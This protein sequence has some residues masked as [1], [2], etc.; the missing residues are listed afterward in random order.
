MTM[1]AMWKWSAEE[2]AEHVR[3]GTASATEV[4][5]AHLD[6]LDDVNPGINAVTFDVRESALAAAAELDATFAASG[7]VGPLHGV[8]ITIKENHDVEGQPS[9][10]G[11]VAWE[12]RIAPADAPM[13]TNLRQAGAVIVGRTNAPELSYRWHTDNPLRGETKNPWSRNRTP[14]GSSGGAAASLAA[15]IGTIAHGN[16]LGGSIRQPANCCGLVGI[17]PTLGRI[18]AFNPSNEAPLTIGLQL[19]SAQGPLAR[20]VADAR[21]A[22][23][24]M[25]QP[26]HDDPWHRA[27]PLTPASASTTAV[28]A[29]YGF[30]EVD[31][32]VKAAVDEAARLLAEAGYDV[33]FVDPPHLEEMPEQWRRILSTEVNVSIP[34]EFLATLS[35]D[36]QQTTAVMSDGYEL[37]VAG[38]VLAYARRLDILRHWT[39]FLHGDR[40]VVG[41]V[42]QRLPFGPNEDAS[43]P[44]ALK[45]I[46]AGH[47]LL[48]SVNY[49][50]LPGIAVPVS[51][52][53]DGPIGV[54]IIGA[55]FEEGRCLD[56]AAI[57]ERD[58]GS[59]PP[60][61]WER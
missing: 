55:P 13:V 58:V 25:M 21:L 60:R 43:T 30:G 9:P 47:S 49:L 26:S 36:V 8:P 32:E 14:G 51:M 41:P 28:A 37:D 35:A 56:A 2:T 19:M 40:I 15:G 57:I 7:P 59:M 46:L 45:R 54:Q 16:D 61:L 20:T 10:N 34:A 17:R 1:D 48:V 18:P 6:R 23:E 44:D 29:T 53:E 12:N 42:S 50:G 5:Q 4:A 11:V 27:M 52:T 39:Q 33:E 24:V 3:A 31:P 38:L 22:L